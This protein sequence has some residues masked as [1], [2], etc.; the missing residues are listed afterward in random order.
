MNDDVLLQ[1]SLNDD[2]SLVALMT[3]RIQGHW[4]QRFEVAIR[5]EHETKHEVSPL[6]ETE[7]Y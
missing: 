5:L 1:Y 6:D 3:N 7:L 4:T 2:L